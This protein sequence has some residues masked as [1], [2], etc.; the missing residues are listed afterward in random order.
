MAPINKR[1]EAVHNSCYCCPFMQACQGLDDPPDLL[2]I[3][4]NNLTIIFVFSI[5]ICGQTFGRKISLFL[6]AV[7]MAWVARC[8]V[9]IIIIIIIM[10]HIFSNQDKWSL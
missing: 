2:P 5:A 7:L 4:L 6:A 1:S 3:T 9:I 8:T 10:C